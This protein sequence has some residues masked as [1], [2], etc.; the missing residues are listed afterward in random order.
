[1]AILDK[2]RS[3]RLQSRAR[4]TCSAGKTR[5]VD[6][7]GESLERDRAHASRLTRAV[8]DLREQVVRV[9]QEEKRVLSEA[10]AG[11]DKSLANPGKQHAS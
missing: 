9:R 10:L 5:T 7:R 2:L 8:C 3:N 6:L 1:M 4:L 11:T